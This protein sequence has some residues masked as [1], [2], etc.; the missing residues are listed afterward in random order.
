M[1]AEIYNRFTQIH[2]SVWKTCFINGHAP[3]QMG[4]MEVR[5]YVYGFDDLA[6]KFSQRLEIKLW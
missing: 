3:D 1:A 6:I 4:K 2:S 5:S